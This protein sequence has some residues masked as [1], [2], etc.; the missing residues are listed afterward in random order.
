MPG[1][2]QATHHWYTSNTYLQ[3]CMYQA[4]LCVNNVCVCVCVCVC[5][6][7]PISGSVFCVLKRRH[8]FEARD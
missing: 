5:E 1:T 7:G 6:G 2:Q 4:L 3:D 8:R